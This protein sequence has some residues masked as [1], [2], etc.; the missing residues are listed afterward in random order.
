MN[1]RD[2]V[3]SLH[4]PF[5]RRRIRITTVAAFVVA[6]LVAHTSA[7]SDTVSMTKGSQYAESSNEPMIEEEIKVIGERT[8]LTL[9]ERMRIYRELA[10]ARDLYSAN[11]IDEA[12][13]LLL[14]TARKGFKNAQARVGHIYLRGLGEIEQDPVEALGWLGVAASGTSSPPI[15]NHFNDI[16]KRIPDKYVDSFEEVVEEYRAKYG[17]NATGVVCE[18]NRPV[19]SFVK[20]L[21]CY[22]EQDLPDMVREPLDHHLTADERERMLERQQEMILQAVESRQGSPVPG[23]NL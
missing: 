16:W 20:Q 1:E 4:T 22:F 9:D 11:K 8:P 17:E 10:R 15:R 18:L 12:F 23:G 21:T 2:P 5:E 7:A 13:P 14:K 3:K 6:A 19:R